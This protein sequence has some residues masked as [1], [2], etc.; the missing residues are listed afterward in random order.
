MSE[1]IC[2][3]CG[4]H[5]DLVLAD[6]VCDSCS[7]ALEKQCASSAATDWVLMVSGLHCVRV[8]IHLDTTYDH[9]KKIWAEWPVQFPG[10]LLEVRPTAANELADLRSYWGAWHN[11]SDARFMRPATPDEIAAAHERQCDVLVV[12]PPASSTETGETIGFG[13][14]A[15]RLLVIGVALL[16]GRAWLNDEELRAGSRCLVAKTTYGIRDLGRAYEDLEKSRR[17]GDEIGLAQ[18]IERDDVALLSP[19]TYGLVIDTDFWKHWSFY[20]QVRITSGSD[21]GK[22]LWI[23]LN[24]LKPAANPPGS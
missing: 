9:M 1:G 24:A 3:K 11:R 15:L 23:E 10:R 17:A 2:N 12:T 16:V 7:D 20:R 14:W 8:H 22:A 21:L 6:R 5:R 13:G 19:G 18:L 4:Q